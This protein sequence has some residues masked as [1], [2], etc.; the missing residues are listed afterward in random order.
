M[1]TNPAHISSLL[2]FS[3]MLAAI[4][5]GLFPPTSVQAQETAIVTTDPLSDAESDAEIE[6]VTSVSQLTD[7]KPTDWAFQAVRSL[8]ERYGCIVGYPDK[9]FGGNR[10]LTRY[11]FAAGLNACLDKMQQILTTR[12]ADL[13]TREDME[14]VKRMMEDFAPELAALRGR[15][16][17]LEVRTETLQKQQ[18]STTTKL[19]GQAIF[20]L[21]GRNSPDIRLG[22]FRFNDNSNQ[23]NVITNVQ[24]SLYTALSDR[25]ILF[26][27]LQ[28]GSGKSYSQLL[29]NNGL[30]GYEG[31][32]GSAIRLSDLTF[33]HLFGSNFA[34]IAGTQGVNMI[35]V[36]RGANRIESAGQGPLSFLAQRNPILNLGASGGSGIN[37]G[38]GFDWQIGT[39]F[40]LQ[41]VY[42][43]NRAE[44]PSNGGL[45]GGQNGGTTAA[46]QL[47]IAPTNTLDIALHYANSYSPSGFLGT[48][49]GDDQMALP[50]QLSPF[51]RAPI[52]TNAIGGTFSWRITP[53][54]TLGGWAGYTISNL[55]GFSGAVDTINWMAFLNFPDLLA[56]GNL[57][58]IYVGQ[59]PAIFQ[60][61]LPVGRNIPDFINGGNLLASAPGGQP[62]RTTHVELFY[63]YRL[64]DNLSL[65]PGV[66]LIFS[67]NNNPTNDTITIGVLRTTFSF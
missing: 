66:I 36:F 53:R 3:P 41:G 7:V 30:L 13:A 49:T 67:P 15:I 44:D 24:L 17:A 60:S 4:V 50:T 18:F 16:D 20:G 2:V 21:Q 12:T 52:Q 34:I 32:T 61:S 19:F 26:T 47:T 6:Q 11:E 22:G 58:G 35:N 39:R 51:V 59:P 25:S 45:F 29:T 27:G 23:V 9:T 14:K 5:L 31:D 65:T 40:S 63:R 54:I 55:K 48:G 42:F 46:A 43:T 62:G 38:A 56:A 57:G 1:T 28:A 37:A 33:R 8:V 64:N 10:A